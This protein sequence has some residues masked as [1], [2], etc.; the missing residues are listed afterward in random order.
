[1]QYL[2]AIS[3]NLAQPYIE[4]E[5]RCTT[6]MSH[7]HHEASDHWQLHCLFNSFFKLSKE[8]F[9]L[10]TLCEQSSAANSPFLKCLLWGI[11]FHASCP[12]NEKTLFWRKPRGC[13]K[14]RYEL[15]NL[16]LLKLS[17]L[18][19][20]HIFQCMGKI[21]CVEFQRV[22]LKF[23]TNILPIHW[24]IWILFTSENLRALRYKS[25]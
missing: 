8:R 9:A 16:R 20:N 14:N 3:W 18:Y 23:H 2:F 1:M 21:F 10:L 24:N 6:V 25:P 22:P 12:H 7:E 15:F 4:N 19:K 5:T 11:H 13:F 17:M